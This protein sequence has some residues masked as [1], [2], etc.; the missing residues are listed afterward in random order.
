MTALPTLNPS[1]LHF[2]GL[3]F[4][5]MIEQSLF[6]FSSVPEK[7]VAYPNY[8]IEIDK[9]RFTFYFANA[10]LLCEALADLLR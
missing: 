5:L 4:I 6:S 2:S 10:V 1:L 7:K 9:R 8:R 3:G